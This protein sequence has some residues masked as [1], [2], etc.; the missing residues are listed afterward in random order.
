MRTLLLLLSFLG[1][2]GCTGMPDRVEPVKGFELNRYLGSWYE[3]ARLDHSFEA[4]LSQVT[5][6]YSM[7]E[8]G[9]VSVLN[10]G[11]SADEN[12]WREAEGKAYFVEEPDTGYLKVSFFGPFYGSYVIFE[13]DKQN[14][15]YAFVSGPD[16]DYLWLLART[17]QVEPEVIDKFEQMAKDRGFNTDQL[18]YVDQQVASAP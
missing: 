18:I 10:R 5:A 17:P 11:F 13:L 2:S 1:L 16:T 9:G 14:Y 4:G 8:D 3:I 12:T 6:N 7:R 15:Q